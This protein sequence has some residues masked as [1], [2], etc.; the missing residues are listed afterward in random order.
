M[1]I[2]ICTDLTDPD[3]GMITYTMDPTNGGRLEGTMATHS[4]DAGFMLSGGSQRNC[5][6]NRVWTGGLITCPCVFVLH[7]VLLVY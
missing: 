3:D 5:Q 7:C 2:A 6:A 1:H 4:C